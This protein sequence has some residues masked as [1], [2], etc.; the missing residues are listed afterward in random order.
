M[1]LAIVLAFMIVGFIDDF[2]KIKLKRNL[3]LTAMQKTLFQLII[4]LWGAFYVYESGLDFVYIPFT[5]KRL[6]LGYF[7]IILNVIAFIATVNSVNLIDGL[8]GL[9]GGTS[10][11]YLL[12][13]LLIVFVEMSQNKDF[14]I[15]KE[16]YYSLNLLSSCFAPLCWWQ[17]TDKQD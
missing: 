3:G 7:S 5:L 16:E 13:S 11:S 12:F 6:H 8:D 10:F 2:L 17:T 15:L 1:V 14:Y 4:S 9:C